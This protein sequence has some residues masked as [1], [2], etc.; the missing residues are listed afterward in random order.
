V[1][2]FLGSIS[3]YVDDDAQEGESSS[4][5]VAPDSGHNGHFPNKM[6]I[7]LRPQVDKQHAMRG[8]DNL[9]EKE[10]L[11]TLLCHELGHAV[12]TL[13]E[14]PKQHPMRRALDGELPGETQAWDL[15]AKMGAYIDPTVK[16]RCL[17]SYI[18]GDEEMNKDSDLKFLRT[19]TK[20]KLALEPEAK[21]LLED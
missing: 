12:A 1:K 11:Q 10:K 14:E 4:C 13:T 3:V 19:L 8:L 6:E 7:V 5:G 15:A 20:M 18:E 2:K 9:T 17:A 16:R 21:W